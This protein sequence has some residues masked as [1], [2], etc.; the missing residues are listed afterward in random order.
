MLI[1]QIYASIL[2]MSVCPFI[3]SCCPY[4]SNGIVAQM[5]QLPAREQCQV[6][7]SVDFIHWK[8]QTSMS[9]SLCTKESMDSSVM[10]SFCSFDD[11]HERSDHL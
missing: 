3:L 2:G 6:I 11:P 4:V 8:A 5:S 9:V 1:V 7:H 10:A